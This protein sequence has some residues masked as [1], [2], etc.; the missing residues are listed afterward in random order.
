MTNLSELQSTMFE[1][2]TGP[3]E[4]PDRPA[5]SLIHA[6]ALKPSVRVGIYAE[7]YWLRMRDVLRDDFPRVLKEVGDEAFDTL[8]A[9]YI[10]AHPSTHFSLGALGHSFAQSLDEPRIASLAALDWARNQALVAPNSPVIAAIALAAINEVSFASVTLEATASTRVV[11][12]PPS[13]VVWRRDFEVF[14]VEVSPAEADA[15]ATLTKGR[16]LLSAL[17]EPFDT[18]NEAFTAIAS[19]ASAHSL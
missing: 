17:C 1:W 19:N 5:A 10:R 13:F 12:G 9:Q 3:D 18:P 8:V 15:L 14:H 4:I 11:R 6:R 16:A 2:I 7:M